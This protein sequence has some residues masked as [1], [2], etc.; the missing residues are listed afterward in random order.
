[1]R[2][3]DKFIIELLMSN[4]DWSSKAAGGI[5]MW[6]YFAPFVAIV[7]LGIAAAVWTKGLKRYTGTGN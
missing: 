2:Q 1:M 7:M 5:K 6:Q 3:E 4:T